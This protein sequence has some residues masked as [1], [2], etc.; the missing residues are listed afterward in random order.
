MFRKSHFPKVS[1]NPQGPAMLS[2]R[3]GRTGSPAGSGKVVS[4]LKALC[5]TRRGA[6]CVVPG[7]IWGGSVLRYFSATEEGI[8]L[9]PGFAA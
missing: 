4:R 9:L 5:L 2:A 6:V 8:N 1:M 3:R 7:E